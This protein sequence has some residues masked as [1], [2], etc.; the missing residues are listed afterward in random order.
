MLS[1]G[2]PAHD[3]VGLARFAVRQH[4]ILGGRRDICTIQHI[5][6][7]EQATTRRQP[8]TAVCTPKASVGATS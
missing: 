3:T 6:L 4:P 1:A 7:L 8:L 2:T 5:E